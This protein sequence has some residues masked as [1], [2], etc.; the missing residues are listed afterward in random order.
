MVLRSLIRLSVM[1][2]YADF[3]CPRVESYYGNITLPIISASRVLI[4]AAERLPLPV[5]T[6]LTPLTTGYAS[7][8]IKEL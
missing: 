7:F 2:I 5:L 6:P 3:A 1:Q 4:F 8:K